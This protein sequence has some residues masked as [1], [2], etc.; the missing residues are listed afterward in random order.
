MSLLRKMKK[1]LLKINAPSREQEVCRALQTIFHDMN[2]GLTDKEAFN[3]LGWEYETKEELFSIYDKDKIYLSDG[4]FKYE[5]SSLE[6]S[7]YNYLFILKNHKILE[8]YI[9]KTI[10]NNKEKIDE[11]RLGLCTFTKK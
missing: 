4:N 9:S 3:I 1:D 8:S 5:S 10:F 2:V 7:N 6:F 11:I